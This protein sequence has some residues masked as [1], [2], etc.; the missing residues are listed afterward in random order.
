MIIRNF[1]IIINFLFTS[2]KLILIKILNFN[3]FR[4]SFKNLISFKSRISLA[5]KGSMIIENGVKV[6]CGTVLS[7]LNNGKLVIGK[8]SFINNNCYIV[9]HKNIVVGKNVLI[10]P[11]VI[12][13][14]H[15]HDFSNGN[16]EKKHYKKNEILIGNNVW[17]GGNT[18]I[19]KGTTIGDNSIIGAGSVVSGKIPEKSL[20]IQKRVNNISPVK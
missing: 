2:L 20:F 3:S 18:V 14:D 8:D 12:I 16:I 7:A 11:N 6:N 13:V 17:I 1:K 10:G 4:F 15:D 9:A 5:N 19:L